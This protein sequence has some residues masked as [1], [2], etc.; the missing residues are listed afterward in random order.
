M[1]VS[2]FSPTSLR[3]QT[4]ATH[5]VAE[6]DPRQ[7]FAL[8]SVTGC[9]ALGASTVSY[10]YVL[11]VNEGGG[12]VLPAS[13][14]RQGVAHHTFLHVFECSR[15]CGKLLLLSSSVF[16]MAHS[17]TAAAGRWCSLQR[18]RP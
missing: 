18:A 8:T 9:S 15:P 6:L 13:R 4:L 17:S 12:T 1:S 2:A 5:R 14:G 11:Q 10:G 3:S 7:S 16:V